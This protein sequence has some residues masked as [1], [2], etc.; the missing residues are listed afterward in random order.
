M[1]WLHGWISMRSLHN[2]TDNT[3]VFRQRE[4]EWTMGVVFH[5]LWRLLQGQCSSRPATVSAKACCRVHRKVHCKM[6]C[7]PS[8]LQI[9]CNLGYWITNF[10]DSPHMSRD[11]AGKLIS[12]CMASRSG[13]KRIPE[14][15]KKNPLLFVEVKPAVQKISPFL[16]QLK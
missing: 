15:C 6:L 13:G 2:G 16:P 3:M 8:G 14:I 11:R 10:T 5:W 7:S 4:N 9:L 1:R 12:H